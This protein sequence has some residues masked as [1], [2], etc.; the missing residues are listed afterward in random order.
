M[1]DRNQ[2]IVISVLALIALLI[3]YFKNP[4]NLSMGKRAE[5]QG[6]VPSTIVT[7]V[8]TNLSNII[9]TNVITNTAPVKPKPNPVKELTLREKV[10]GTYERLPR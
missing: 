1:P 7:N 6:P 2:I 9:V 3:G 5:V 4:L 8:I 10:I